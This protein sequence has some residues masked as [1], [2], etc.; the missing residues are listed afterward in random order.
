MIPNSVKIIT[1]VN[2][3]QFRLS[4]P[5]KT[6]PEY[7]DDETIEKVLQDINKYD[8]FAFD[9]IQYTRVNIRFDIKL[10]YNKK[11]C[12]SSWVNMSYETSI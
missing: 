3:E 12:Y 9:E 2:G 11:T 7:I 5:A 10:F 8:V 1:I 4:I 6:L